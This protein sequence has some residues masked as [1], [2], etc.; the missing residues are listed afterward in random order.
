MYGGDSYEFSGL[1]LGRARGSDWVRGTQG[2]FNSVTN[3]L[4]FKLGNGFTDVHFII[5]IFCTL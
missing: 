3:A 5:S 2:D 4:L 1:F